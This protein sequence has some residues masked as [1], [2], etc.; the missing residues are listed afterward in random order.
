MVTSTTSCFAADFAD[1]AIAATP[2]I[3]P[4]KPY[5]RF[6]VLWCGILGVSAVS[7]VNMRQCSESCYLG[8]PGVP[9]RVV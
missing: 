6:G 7:R 4:D 1:F 5:A 2:D 3:A 8:S 9:F